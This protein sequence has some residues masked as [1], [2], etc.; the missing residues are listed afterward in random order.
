MEDMVGDLQAGPCAI[1]ADGDGDEWDAVIEGATDDKRMEEKAEAV[2]MENAHCH[3]HSQ[4]SRKGVR[5]VDHVWHC[6]A[7]LCM[8][9]TSRGGD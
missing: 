2:A 5:Q 7:P 9:L 4:G 1:E 8:R 3:R 6:C